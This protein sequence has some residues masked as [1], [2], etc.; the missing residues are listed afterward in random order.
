MTTTATTATIPLPLLRACL[1]CFLVRHCATATPRVLHDA[2]VPLL[3]AAA[4]RE[5]I[6]GHAPPFGRAETLTKTCVKCHLALHIE[7]IGPVIPG[8][9]DHL[10]AGHL[11]DHT[12]P[13]SCTQYPLTKATQ[14]LSNLHTQ[15]LL[16]SS[17]CAFLAEEAQYQ[18]LVLG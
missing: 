16:G 6:H 15:H 5:R 3:S 17:R 10:A 14:L 4:A 12:A 9:S 7:T 18:P 13:R 2:A 1:S 8:R 11:D